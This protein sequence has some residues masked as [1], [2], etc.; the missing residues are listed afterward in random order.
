MKNESRFWECECCSSLL[1]TAKQDDATDYQCPACHAS[2][3]DDGGNYTEITIEAFCNEAGI[4]Q[5]EL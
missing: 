2:R 3:C 4:P 5:A 1:V